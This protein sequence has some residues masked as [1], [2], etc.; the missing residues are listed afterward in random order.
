MSDRL[1]P[2]L[3]DPKETSAIWGGDALVRRYGK[4][5]D[6]AQLLGESWECWDEN[7]VANAAG[8]AD[9]GRCVENSRRN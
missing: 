4:H 1:Y 3:I 8:G 2:Y 7:R 5:G 9:G 6:P